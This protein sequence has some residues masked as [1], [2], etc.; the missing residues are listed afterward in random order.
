MRV[1]LL[2]GA[3]DQPSVSSL[4]RP[5]ITTVKDVTKQQQTVNVDTHR[6][7]SCVSKSH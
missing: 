3:K 1:A 6:F 4:S 7:A 2:G 5:P